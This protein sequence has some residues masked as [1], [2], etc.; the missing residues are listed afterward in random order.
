MNSNSLHIFVL[1]GYPNKIVSYYKYGIIYSYL[2][3]VDSCDFLFVSGFSP[4]S[5]AYVNLQLTFTYKHSFNAIYAINVY[6]LAFHKLLI[7]LQ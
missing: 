5:F 6:F 4:H 1:C 2:Q 3:L 7:M